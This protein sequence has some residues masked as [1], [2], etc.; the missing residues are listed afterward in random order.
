VIES[1]VKEIE[2]LMGLRVKR[3]PALIREQDVRI[4]PLLSTLHVNRP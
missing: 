1:D 3:L 2:H 4:G